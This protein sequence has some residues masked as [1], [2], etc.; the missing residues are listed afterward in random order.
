MGLIDGEKTKTRGT[1]QG[2]DRYHAPDR[3][4]QLRPNGESAGPEG[5]RSELITKIGLGQIP[6]GTEIPL[7]GESLPN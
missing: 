2:C 1:N 5:G 6:L 4:Q 3:D 7:L